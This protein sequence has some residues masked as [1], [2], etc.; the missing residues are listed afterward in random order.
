MSWEPQFFSDA[1]EIEADRLVR[2]SVALKQAS[3]SLQ[4][5][6]P[7]KEIREFLRKGLLRSFVTR[8]DVSWTILSQLPR[9]L[10]FKTI[11][12]RIQ[13]LSHFAHGGHYVAGFREVSK[14][15][16]HDATPKDE[17]IWHGSLS[18]PFGGGAWANWLRSEFAS[19]SEH[20]DLENDASDEDEIRL[21]VVRLYG[22][23]FLVSD[24]EALFPQNRASQTAVV[25]G[26]RQEKYDWATAFAA[27]SGRQLKYDFLPDIYAPGAQAKLAI[28]LA[29]WFSSL[30]GQEPGET[31]LKEKAQLLLAHWR[32]EDGK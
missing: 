3:D 24:F 7:R 28:E 13:D 20:W 23:G 11:E 8:A 18:F 17:G 31:M 4:I 12:R 19:I 14:A 21:S 1:E 22:V 9:P 29:S 26:G 30:T 2:A 27:V 5:S 16:W 6:D 15:F 25:K 32:L 10:D